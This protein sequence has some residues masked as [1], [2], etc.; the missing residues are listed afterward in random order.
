[1]GVFANILAAPKCTKDTL[2]AL[3][4]ESEKENWDIDASACQALPCEVGAAVS[5]NDHCCGYEEM[6]QALSRRLNGA[7]M[8]CYIYD[9][10]LWGYYFY[11]AGQEIDSFCSDPDYFE[12]V[13]VQERLRLKGNAEVVAPYFF[14]M[15]DW[16]RS[17][18]V[19]W[20]DEDAGDPWDMARFLDVLG[21]H[22]PENEE[23]DIDKEELFG[24]IWERAEEDRTL[25][26]EQFVVLEERFDELFWT[27][28]TLSGFTD[29]VRALYEETQNPAAR[30]MLEVLPELAEQA[31]ASADNEMQDDAD[32]AMEQL[33]LYVDAQKIGD[34]SFC[35]QGEA[36]TTE[37]IEVLCRR[38]QQG[39]LVRLEFYWTG[40]TE[41]FG[42]SLVLLRDDA[43]WAC[44]Y[45]DDSEHQSY[46]MIAN[47]REYYVMDYKELRFVPFHMGFLHSCNVYDAP[48][49]ILRNLPKTFG[50]CAAQGLY[51]RADRVWSHISSSVYYNKQKYNEEKRLLGGFPVER[52]LNLLS[53]QIGFTVYPK[54]LTAVTQEGDKRTLDTTGVNRDMPRFYLHRFFQKNLGQLAFHFD[55]NRHLVL[56]EDSGN[57]LLML[58][59]DEM[60]RAS[61]CM[62]EKKRYQAGE[63]IP[64]TDFR[65]EP[66]PA[67]CVFTDMEKLRGTA[68]LLLARMDA[69]DT[70]LSK[71]GL[72]L[73]GNPCS[74]HGYG[75]LRAQFLAE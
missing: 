22:L 65:G 48:E 12:E 69:P 36:V 62:T 70:I 43:K 32:K 47:A 61:F 25:D 19:Q 10:D 24:I 6:T 8:L 35:L 60:Q 63:Q 21:V 14:T 30:W 49:E 66:V 28:D 59:E 58:F 29:S 9:D 31:A 52:S 23:E 71:S 55:G 1:M 74:E 40:Q 75:A 17:Y 15:P 20:N 2:L 11:D 68:E 33:V 16:I 41:V 3:V 39:E 51:L 73:S 5:L 42:R 38:Y 53:D 56:L 13:S 57:M 27:S 67:V 18:L 34:E 37:A 72:Y 44:L 26:Y 64:A 50:K 45:F 7:L 46:A 54:T 4:A